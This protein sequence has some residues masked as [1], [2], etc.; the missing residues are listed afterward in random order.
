MANGN[1]ARSKRSNLEARATRA[2]T[3]T[4]R[5]T[6]TAT[7]RPGVTS[8]D[9]NSRRPVKSTP[10]PSASPTG[11]M[12]NGRRKCHLRRWAT[13]SARHPTSASAPPRQAEAWGESPSATTPPSWPSRT[14]AVRLAERCKVPMAAP[15]TATPPNTA[16]AAAI[17]MAAL[18]WVISSTIKDD[19][20]P[21]Q[22]G[23]STDGPPGRF[24]IKRGAIIKAR[25]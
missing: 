14:R 21:P 9:S 20:S 10:T 1:T 5:R 16:A 12:I 24:Q 19:N 3:S 6:K 7:S 2:A 11:S 22:A 17:P 13:S 18:R 23:S 8:A 15:T 4:A 25:Q